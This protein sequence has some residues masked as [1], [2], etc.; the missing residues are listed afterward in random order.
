MEVEIQLFEEKDADELSKMIYKAIAELEKLNPE[1]DYSLIRE[2]DKPAELIKASKEGRMWVA[3]TDGKLAGTLSLTGN[4]L[5]R[6]F[7]HPAYQRRGIGGS[8]VKNL[9]RHAKEA[10]IRELYVGAI[11]SA[12]SVYKKLGFR[13]GEVFFNPEINQKEMKMKL[14]LY[15]TE[16]L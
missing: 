9:I 7:V 8:L 2:E 4:R 6:F 5:R 14:I 15:V 3:I 11:L 13:E 1:L 10:N 12:V 16:K